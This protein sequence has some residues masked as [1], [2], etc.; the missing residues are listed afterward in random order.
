MIMMFGATPLTPKEVRLTVSPAPVDPLCSSAMPRSRCT[1][2][3]RSAQI[4]TFRF[5]CTTQPG[6]AAASQDTSKLTRALLR[7]LIGHGL[8]PEKELR[9]TKVWV[10]APQQR[11]TRWQHLHRALR[12]QS[13]RQPASC[14]TVALA[15]G[16]PHDPAR[17]AAR[18]QVSAKA[19]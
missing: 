4:Y 2:A 19:G 3:L 6:P 8:M 11:P 14:L 1:V 9:P 16:R 18:R 5:H 12:R 10:R 13:G 7:E 15:A 17:A